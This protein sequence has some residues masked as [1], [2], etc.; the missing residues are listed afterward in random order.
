M[1]SA[2]GPSPSVQL[3]SPLPRS[4]G[5]LESASRGGEQGPAAGG[6]CGAGREASGEDGRPAGPASL[7]EGAS[8]SGSSSDSSP[9]LSP[10][11]KGRGGGPIH[12]LPSLSFTHS[13]GAVW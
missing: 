11:G 3:D 12:Q 6:S 2:A 8:V 13:K 4:V 7:V 9:E 1:V 10:A 5:D